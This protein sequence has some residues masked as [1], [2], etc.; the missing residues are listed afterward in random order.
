LNAPGDSAVDLGPFP[1]AGGWARRHFEWPGHRFDL[2]VPAQPDL[3]L[4][5]PAVERRHRVDDY[6]PYWA[7]LWPA[8]LETAAEVFRHPWPPGTTVLEIGAGLALPGFAF[9]AAGCAVTVTDY[10]E[11]ALVL[12]H[13]NAR[14]N[15]WHD[16]V[17]TLLLDWRHPPDRRFP[18]I[19]GC[20]VIYERR[21]HPLV[22]GVLQAM[23]APGGVAW[24]TDPD[25]HQAH[26][27]LARVA[28]SPFVCETRILPRLPDP[29]RPPGTTH[30]HQLRWRDAPLS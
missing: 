7:H 12:A 6:M 27:F 26:E 17:E 14:L 16:G 29:D 2:L 28:D 1:L 23:L 3:L 9:R 24:I 4:D 15:G 10:D 19:L 21:N 20:E 8:S 5:D 25:R 13:Q 11:Q 18:V 22:L 30:L